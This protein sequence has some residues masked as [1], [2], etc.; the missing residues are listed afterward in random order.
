MRSSGNA[1]PSKTRSAV[2]HSSPINRLRLQLPYRPPDENKNTIRY[3][4]EHRNQ[5]ESFFDKLAKVDSWNDATN[6]GP[7]LLEALIPAIADL[8]QTML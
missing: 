7:D 5:A 8:H 2:A 1:V 6:P 3:S 4:D